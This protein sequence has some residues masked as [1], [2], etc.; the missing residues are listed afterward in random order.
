MSYRVIIPPAIASRI[1]G[2]GLSDAVFVD[3][4]LFLREVLPTAPTEYLQ[5]RRQPFDGM[6]YEFSLIDPGNR[7]REHLFAFHVLYGQDEQT[8]VIVKGG[9]RR[10]D[11]I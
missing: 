6:V 2:W 10:H 9:Y 1:A 7:L 5:R 4:Y 3:V 11:G 8:L